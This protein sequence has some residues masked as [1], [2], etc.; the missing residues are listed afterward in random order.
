M[1]TEYN[2]KKTLV[3]SEVENLIEFSG[4][5]DAYSDGMKDCK[6]RG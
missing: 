6:T 5:P 1:V 4:G 3:C 2:I